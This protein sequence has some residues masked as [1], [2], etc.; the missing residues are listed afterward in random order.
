MILLLA[1]AAPAPS[2]SAPP[3][4]TADTADSAP[5]APTG[6]GLLTWEGAAS[7]RDGWD[8]TETVTFRAEL[9]LGDVL[10]ELR[11][12]VAGADPREDCPSCAIAYEVILGA[13]DVTVADG[14][15]AAGYDA[16]AI[17]AIEGTTRG[18]GFATD[19]YGHASVLLVDEGGGWD[20][21]AFADH[22]DTAGTLSYSWDHGY[23]D[24]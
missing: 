13:P 5:P 9:G 24:Y 20:A 6:T 23:I 19:Y 17:A 14:C 7:I 2:D 10:C 12:T 22:D 3:I 1:C 16:A 18:Y 8:G 15:G 21:A 4:D 11:Y